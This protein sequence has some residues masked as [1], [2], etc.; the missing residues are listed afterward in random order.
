MRTRPFRAA[1]AAVAAAVLFVPT[2][3]PALRAQA[4]AGVD[5]AL[6]AGLRWRSV[7]PAR[8]GRSIAVA[9]S[10][11]RRNEYYFGATGGGLWKT[12]DGGLTWRAVSDGFFK[13]S[14]VGAVAVSESQPD[15][16]YAGMGEVQL[17]GNVIQ[18]DGVYKSA[19][20]GRTWTHVG[21]ERTM[22]VS[23]IRV[24][25][26]NPDIVYVA[27]LG[28]PYG[29][30][31]ERGIF[32]SS[33]GGKTWSSVLSRNDQ[34]GAADLSM[35]PKNPDVLYAGFWEVFR[36]PHS[37]S[38]GGP[39]S[40]LFKT[41]DGGKTWTELTKN[42]GLPA[43]LWGKVGVS[44]SGADGNRV[45]AII[46]AA[47]GGVFLSDDA[48]A[49]W[50]A[51]QRRPPPASARVL[52]HPHLRRPAGAR[53]R[54][55]PQHR[56]LSFDRRRQDARR[57]PRAARR[58]PRPLDR[59][60]RAGAAD[61]QQ[62][63]RRATSRP[64]AARAGPSRTIRP[65]SSTTSSPPRTCRITSAARS[66]TTQ[67]RACRRAAAASSTPS[68]AARAATSRPIR[69]TSTSSMPAATAACSRA[70]TAGRASAGPSTSGRTIRWAS[71]PRTSPSGF[72]G[73]SRSSSRRPIRRRSTRPRSTSGNPPTK[74]RA[75]SAS[76]PT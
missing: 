15:V 8:G 75:G 24:H 35:D 57:D 39:G 2:P 27:A 34:T 45:Y 21:L 29:P 41:T 48:G 11:S 5:A 1:I 55:H 61:Q 64:T 76:A 47:E 32:K 43:P 22:V 9:G 25:P 59:A 74:A 62:R 6:L 3:T 66:R 70:S 23:R 10:N 13:T 46:E 38:S 17:R 53:H 73:R 37:L 16:V 30:N 7:G 60:L 68:A 71:R 54:L 31:P 33:D 36:T 14:S 18:G 49:T 44:V 28:D 52:L 69:R 58:Q 65:R 56:H 42:P 67:R 20:A 40:G 72:S 19:D 4:A 51:R 12:A 26:T 50:S 63:R